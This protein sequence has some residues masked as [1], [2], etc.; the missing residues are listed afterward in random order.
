M[1]RSFSAPLA[2]RTTGKPESPEPTVASST[3]GSSDSS[4]VRTS[5]SQG[6]STRMPMMLLPTTTL[7]TIAALATMFSAPLAAQQ[8][9]G[10]RPLSLA[11][12][13]RIAET[14]SEDV[15]IARAATDRARGEQLR[16]RSEL[17]PQVFASVDYTNRK[18]TRLNSSHS[19][20][21]YAV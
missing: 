9:S 18:S 8:P 21:S 6:L 12:A 5:K 13:L 2:W 15:G 4:R 19:Q 17:F 3:S 7:V 16:A 20:I 1:Q 14:A 11:D 10:G